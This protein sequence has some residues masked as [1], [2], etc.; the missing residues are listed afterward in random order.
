MDM[1][2]YS[3]DMTSRTPTRYYDMIIYSMD[4]RI[5]NSGTKGFVIKRYYLF[6]SCVNK[7]DGYLF[8]GY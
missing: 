6:K 3:M 8:E 2:I 1:I 5:N 7:S 4:N